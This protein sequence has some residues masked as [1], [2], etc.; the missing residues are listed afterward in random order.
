MVYF[1][2][3]GKLLE[4]IRRVETSR[5]KILS[6][7]ALTARDRIPPREDGEMGCSDV[8]NGEGRK[9]EDGEKKA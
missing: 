6:A 1:S 7:F 5:S 3:V 9:E 2:R 4:S 8:F